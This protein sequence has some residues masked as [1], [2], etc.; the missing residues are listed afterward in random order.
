MEEAFG[1]KEIYLPNNVGNSSLPQVS[2]ALTGSE[3]GS[4]SSERT[5]YVVSPLNI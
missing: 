3:Y 2:I 4:I 1:F 5:L